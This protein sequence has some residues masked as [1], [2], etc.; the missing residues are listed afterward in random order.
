MQ[1]NIP[2]L[3]YNNNLKYEVFD[4]SRRSFKRV[5]KNEG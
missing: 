1:D 3:C 5:E 4:V 2:R